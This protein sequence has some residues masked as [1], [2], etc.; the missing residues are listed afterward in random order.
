MRANRISH[1]GNAVDEVAQIGPGIGR[2]IEIVAGRVGIDCRGRTACRQGRGHTGAASAWRT[3][4]QDGA[5]MSGGRG[6]PFV[7]RWE[8]VFWMPAVTWRDNEKVEVTEVPDPVIE[9]P[10]DAIVRVTS[11][12]ICCSDLH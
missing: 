2:P 5:L 9:E 8:A 7:S 6:W 11:T 1:L 10:T 12:A 3:T 4:G